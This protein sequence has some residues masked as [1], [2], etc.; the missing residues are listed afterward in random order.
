MVFA[1]AGDSTMT[2]RLCCTF[3][4]VTIAAAASPAPTAPSRS[5]I[6]PSHASRP[7]PTTLVAALSWPVL[8]GLY[9]LRGPADASTF[10]PRAASCSPRTTSRASTRGRSGCRSGRAAS[11]ASWRSRS[12]TGGRCGAFMLGRRRVPGAAG[13]GATS[14]RSRPPCG[15][16]ARATSSRCFP[17]GTRRRKGLVKRFEARPRSG[18]GADRARGRRAARARRDR[19]HRPAARGSAPL[20]VAY[21]PPV[22]DRRPPRHRRRPRCRAD[23]DRAADGS[24][25][26]E[27]EASL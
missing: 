21:G 17:K 2:S 23:R 14:R 4:A 13:T 3:A 12:C 9:R 22:A 1:L 7:L 24:A 25:S 10:R 20:R 26:L 5:G 6:L 8:Y 27:L 15:W 11:S 16:R 18:R 19:G